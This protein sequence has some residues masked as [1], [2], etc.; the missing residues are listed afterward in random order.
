MT[1]VVAHPLKYAY[2]RQPSRQPNP[3]SSLCT[4]GLSLPFTP[5]SFPV[6]F[7]HLLFH[8]TITILGPPVQMCASTSNLHLLCFGQHDNNIPKSLSTPAHL[9]SG[10]QIP[11]TSFKAFK[12]LAAVYFQQ[13]RAVPVLTSSLLLLVPSAYTGHTV[14]Q[15]SCLWRS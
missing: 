14:F 3:D 4:P 8:S 12:S 7:A 10:L 5:T 2:C 13:E 11:N 1:L 6:L 15:N 9:S